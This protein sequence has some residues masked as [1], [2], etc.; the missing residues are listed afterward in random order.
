M[1]KLPFCQQAD[2]TR[3]T[4]IQDAALIPSQIFS[5]LGAADPYPFKD[6][7][8]RPGA[9]P[10]YMVFISH[11]APLGRGWYFATLTDGP[12]FGRVAC[13]RTDLVPVDCTNPQY[14]ARVFQREAIRSRL[15]RIKSITDG[16]EALAN[17]LA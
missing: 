2:G 12:S 15:M 17:A 10:S 16:L 4:L 3:W 9:D 6:A 8:A 7:A 13:I 11:L 5:K 1:Q 14:A